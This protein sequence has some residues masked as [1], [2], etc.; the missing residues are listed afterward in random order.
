MIE[1]ANMFSC[2]PNQFCR[3][4][5]RTCQSWLV[6]LPFV[7]NSPWW[8]LDSRSVSQPAILHRYGDTEGTNG[9][10]LDCLQRAEK[11][12]NTVYSQY[13]AVVYISRNWIYR[14]RMLDPIF[15]RPRTQYFSRNRGNSLDPIR[16]RQFFVKF[17]HRDRLCSRS[18]GDNFSRNQ[19]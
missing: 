4:M 18:G 12:L 8:H 5:A 6:E 14:G 3:W 16:G 10:F 13:I 17:D 15:L 19:F 1:N 2:S 11:K 7:G 9:W